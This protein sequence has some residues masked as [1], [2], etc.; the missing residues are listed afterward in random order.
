MSFAD[1]VNHDDSNWM[2]NQCCRFEPGL[3]QG[4]YAMLVSTCTL[5]NFREI[6]SYCI[7]AVPSRYSGY[8]LLFLFNRQAPH[9]VVS[10]FSG[11]RQV[12]YGFVPNCT[13]VTTHEFLWCLLLSALQLCVHVFA[14]VYVECMWY[15]A[16]SRA[17]RAGQSQLFGVLYATLLLYADRLWS[18]MISH[19]RTVFFIYDSSLFFFFL[20]WVM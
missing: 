18:G 9:Q 15:H 12:V 13:Q 3:F 2:A 1:S 7:S 16:R 14:P 11:S 10:L 20:P 17:I 5:D 6:V 19:D 4:V 8:D